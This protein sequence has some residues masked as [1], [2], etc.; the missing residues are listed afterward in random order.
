ML[1][2]YVVLGAVS[3]AALFLLPKFFPMNLTALLGAVIVGLLV[4]LPVYSIS[5]AIA[6]SDQETFH[7]YWNG[8][9][10]AA[11]SDIVACY[12]D[13][14]CHNTYSCDPYTVMVTETYT[15][16]EGHTK[17][18]TVPKTKYHDCPYSKQETS[19][20][21]ESTLGTYT[22]AS[23]LM[24]GERFRGG[25]SIPGGQVTKA[26][27]L[28]S[29]A[30][31]RI[32]AG[33]PGPVAKV[34]NYK[35][36]ILASQNSLLKKYSDEINLYSSK[37]MLPAP[38]AGVVDNYHANKAYFVKTGLSDKTKNALTT[39]VAYL[40]GAVGNN[41]QGDLHVVFVESSKVD[42]PTSY[43]NSL[44]AY[45]QSKEFGRDALAKNALVVVFGVNS[46]TNDIAWTKSATGMPFGNEA[47][48]TQLESSFNEVKIDKSLI[49]RPTYDVKA[50]KV[51]HSN[52]KLEDILFGA[53]KF[54]RVSM[55][56]SDP[57]DK[58]SGFKYLSDEWEPDAGTMAVI[59]VVSSILFLSALAF[60]TYF[61]YNLRTERKP[62][63]VAV[64]FSKN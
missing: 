27:K 53:N 32:D 22:I 47:L 48:I 62:D 6:K 46:K 55:S 58:G 54:V 36:F 52:G 59:Y 25:H 44:T 21:V 4:P 8:Y 50:A 17:T 42:N 10:T 61:S 64:L 24:T 3:I 60:G 41:L 33:A 19:Y 20:Y 43:T 37:G 15:D 2:Y 38:A 49:G 57:S 7:E 29:D 1:V 5:T 31:N 35:N 40:N 14:R 28:W 51:V 9:E 63:P 18:R 39:D 45:W 56:G 23:N 16:S 11:T 30:K 34:N 26:P 13:G 12:R